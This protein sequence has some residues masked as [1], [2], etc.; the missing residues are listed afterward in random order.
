LCVPGSDIVVGECSFASWRAGAG[1]GR[2]GKPQLRTWLAEVW[3]DGSEQ[4]SK[5]AVRP[6]AEQRGHTSGGSHP[7]HNIMWNSPLEKRKV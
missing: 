4:Q 5:G 6:L 7:R 3:G 1:T 2:A